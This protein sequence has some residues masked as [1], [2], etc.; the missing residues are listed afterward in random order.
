MRCC[1]CG[2]IA[3]GYVRR[4]IEHFWHYTRHYPHFFFDVLGLPVRY[5]RYLASVYYVLRLA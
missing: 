3:R 1:R 4:G 2:C 5:A